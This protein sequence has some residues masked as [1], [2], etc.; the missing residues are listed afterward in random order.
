[1]DRARAV[2]LLDARRLPEL[3]HRP[4]LQALAPGQE[5]RAQPGGAAGDRD[6]PGAVRRTSPWAKYMLDRSFEL[7]DRWTERHRALPPANAF[8]VPVDRRQRVLRAA[9]RGARAGQRRPGGAV[10]PRRAAG[11]ASRRR[12]TPTTPTSAASRSPRPPTTRRSWPSRAARSPTAAIELAR[13]FDGDQDVA[14]GV[15]GRPPA[16]F[17]VVVRSGGAI[18]PPPSARSRRPTTTPLRLL[19]A[20][21]G[22]TANPQSYPEPALRGGVRDP[23]RAGL[24]DARRGRDP[25]DPHVQGR[26]HRDRVARERR[27]RQAVEVLFPSWG[28]GAKVTA[29]MKSGGAQ[30]GLRGMSLSDVDRFHVESEHSRLRRDVALRRVRRDRAGAAAERA[31]LARRSR[32]R[33]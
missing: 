1:M 4:R 28:D 25:D 2:G 18:A 24:L 30:A 7:F 23:A 16:S 8:D 10:R 15:G 6:V 22:A 17:G 20:P 19:E 29:V 3:G 33:R 5:A 13:L 27:A 32:G 9:D 11:L 14:G 12:C 21:R 31:V 26:L